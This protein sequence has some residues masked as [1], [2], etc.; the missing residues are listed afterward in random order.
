[1]I[2]QEQSKEIVRDCYQFFENVEFP[3]ML[4]FCSKPMKFE[5]LTNTSGGLLKFVYIG[6]KYKRV[7]PTLAEMLILER[8]KLMTFLYFAKSSKQ[9]SLVDKIGY[10]TAE[11]GT[12][13]V[14]KGI[15]ALLLPNSYI[16]E[17][18]G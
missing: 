5:N 10:D 17:T 16:V 4:N 12:F 14:W 9:K 13:D 15:S 2:Y 1:M 3:R 11:K 18:Q 6:Q 7:S 8:C